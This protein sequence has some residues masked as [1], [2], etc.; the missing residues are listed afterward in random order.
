MR[1]STFALLF[2]LFV[3]SLA[4]GCMSHG[5]ARA[6]YAQPG[7]GRGYAQP[8]YGYAPQPAYGYGAPSPAYRTGYAQPY[9]GGYA[10]PYRGRGYEG[11][12]DQ[13]VVTPPYRGG[14]SVV[15]TPP[16]GGGVVVTVPR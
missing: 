6:R 3:A 7:Y 4:P 2:A 13:V 5:Y 16:R 10:Q 1:R 15:V 12:H 9:R 11:R 14:A 8:V